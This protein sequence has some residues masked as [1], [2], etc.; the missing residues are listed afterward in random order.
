ML[1]K[2]RHQTAT[3]PPIARGFL[4]IGEKPVELSTDKLIVL[5]PVGDD[6]LEVRLTA[7]EDELEDMPMFEG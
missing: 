6:A 2:E 1:S 4:G 5:R 7:T 3:G